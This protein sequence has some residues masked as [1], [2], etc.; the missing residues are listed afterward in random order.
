LLFKMWDF[1]FF[2]LFCCGVDKASSKVTSKLLVLS[3]KCWQ[4]FLLRL[5]LKL[6]GYIIC[7]SC[8]SE[9]CFRLHSTK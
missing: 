2:K 7:F 9:E 3:T 5:L 1:I 6:R 4:L 8:I